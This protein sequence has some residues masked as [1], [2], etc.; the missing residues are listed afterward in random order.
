MFKELRRKEREMDQDLTLE[1]LNSRDYGV[2]SMAAAEDYAYGVPLSFVYRNGAIYFHCALEGHKLDIL[3]QNNKVSFCVVG[4]TKP[5]P[6]QFS[7]GY[8]SVIVFGTVEEVE[9]EEK[10]EGLIA[11]LE[12]YASDNMEKGMKY[13]EKDQHRTKVLKLTI[14]HM[15]GK[16]RK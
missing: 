14:D 7:M 9:G 1:L 8:Q 10:R 4:Q 13:L 6:E 3:S 15:T 12:K 2:L 16:N 5:L 11:L